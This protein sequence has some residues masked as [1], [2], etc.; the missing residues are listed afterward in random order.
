MG[1]STSG[2]GGCGPHGDRA[3]EEHGGGGEATYEGLDGCEHREAA[4]GPVA[5]GGDE[6]GG[7]RDDELGPDEPGH[8]C[9]GLDD[10]G[11]GDVSGDG[12]AELVARGNLGRE[13]VPDERPQQQGRSDS[14]AEQTDRGAKRSGKLCKRRR[15]RT[16]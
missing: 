13:R 12:A 4:G 11:L 10:G 8:E 9:G 16:R 3:D 2:V 7:K 14:E 15:A 1:G 5:H 6:F